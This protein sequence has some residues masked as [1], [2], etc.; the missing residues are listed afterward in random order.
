MT[1]SETIQRRIEAAVDAA[2]EFFS[3]PNRDRIRED[4]TTGFAA[5]DSV[6]LEEAVEVW[7][8]ATNAVGELLR[9]RMGADWECDTCGRHLDDNGCGPRLLFHPSSFLRSSE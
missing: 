4:L 1:D 8:C 5:S 3:S 2:A 6:L 7:Y 9:P